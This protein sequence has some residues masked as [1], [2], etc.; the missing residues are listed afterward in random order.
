M[1]LYLFLLLTQA[2]TESSHS[3]SSPPLIT[4][5][6]L[7]SFP[8]LLFLPQNED[9]EEKEQET[10]QIERF[11]LNV[12]LIE[13]LVPLSRAFPIVNHSEFTQQALVIHRTQPIILSSR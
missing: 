2:R 10:P 12:L 8:A 7:H 3:I 4:L 1:R 5:I 13:P 9:M 6:F 11:V